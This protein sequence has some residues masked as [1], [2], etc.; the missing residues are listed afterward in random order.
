MPNK[1]NV[2]DLVHLIFEGLSCL[3]AAYFIFVELI[4]VFSLDKE[5]LKQG[6]KEIIFNFVPGSLVIAS[7]VLQILYNYGDEEDNALMDQYW[8]LLAWTAFVIWFKFL[9][10]LR[11]SEWLSPIISMVLRSFTDMCSYIIVLMIGI[12]AFTDAF[13]SVNQIIYMKTKDDEE[14]VEPPFDRN[15]EVKDFGDWFQKWMGEYIETMK[16]VFVGAVNGYEAEEAENYTYSQWLIFLGSILFTAIV[17]MNLLLAIVAAVQA[18]V[19][20]IKEYYVY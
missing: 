12:F 5:S 11:H 4:V 8:E 15:M 19:D 13:K 1:D 7:Q 3:L 6:Y 10:M 16:S 18:E 14:P 20:G 2:S 17:L 9:L